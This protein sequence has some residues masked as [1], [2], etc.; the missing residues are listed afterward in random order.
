MRSN[1]LFLFK[2]IN[3]IF[4]RVDVLFSSKYWLKMKGMADWI[5]ICVF[6]CVCAHQRLT[7]AATEIIHMTDEFFLHMPPTGLLMEKTVA[8]VSHMWRVV[9]SCH[10]ACP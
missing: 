1:K 9:H 5:I 2:N 8:S 10:D 3:P 4:K 7:K 6:V